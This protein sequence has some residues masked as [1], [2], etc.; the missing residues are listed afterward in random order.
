MK[1]RCADLSNPLYGGRGIAVCERWLN[2]FEAF[3]A[4][5]GP[6]PPGK[7]LDRIN[8]NGN[9]EPSNCRWATRSEQQRNRRPKRKQHKISFKR[10]R[11][12]CVA[13]DPIAAQDGDSP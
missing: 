7:S 2:S 1:K 5:M 4:D 8:A 10:K 6:R 9:Y 12:A 13:L 3:L 11:F